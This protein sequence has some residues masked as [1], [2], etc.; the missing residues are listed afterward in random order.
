M[1]PS[2]PRNGTGDVMEE[3]ENMI[4]TRIANAKSEHKY[5]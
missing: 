5:G 1:T 3:E 2:V 4:I